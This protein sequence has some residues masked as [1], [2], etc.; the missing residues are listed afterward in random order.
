MQH[1]HKIMFVNRRYIYFKKTITMFYLT[2]K[3]LT[4]IKNK[5]S[6]IEQGW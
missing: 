1:S 2:K 5:Y 3:N 4:Y 6:A